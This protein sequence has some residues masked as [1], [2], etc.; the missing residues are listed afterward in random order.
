MI[1]DVFVNKGLQ[2]MELGALYY[3]FSDGYNVAFHSSFI[4]DDFNTIKLDSHY[5]K[6]IDKLQ[7]TSTMTKLLLKKSYGWIDILGIMEHSPVNLDLQIANYG[8]NFIVS[9]NDIKSVLYTSI[10]GMVH[11]IISRDGYR[12]NCK[13]REDIDLTNSDLFTIEQGSIDHPGY[14]F[15]KRSYFDDIKITAV[16]PLFRWDNCLCWVGGVFADYQID[17]I[18]PNRLWIPKGKDLLTTKPIGYKD[19]SE[20]EN[21]VDDIKITGTQ[22]YGYDFAAIKIFR[23]IGVDISPM[24]VPNRFNMSIVAHRDD[25]TGTTYGV[26]YPKSIIFANEVKES[27]IIMYNGIILDP[28]QYTINPKNRCEV[29]LTFLEEHI[30]SL[31]RRYLVVDSNPYERIERYISSCRFVVI[32]FTNHGDDIPLYMRDDQ[33]CHVN[34]PYPGQIT[35]FDLSLSD[36]IL[37]DGM[38]MPYLWIHDRSIEYPKTVGFTDYN[39]LNKMTV[40]KISFFN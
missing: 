4:Y 33:S 40:R 3:E 38:Y 31:I 27:H 15:S 25:I 37:L 11:K 10:D 22:L 30:A 19:V 9:P 5:K 8:E 18:V 16:D 21:L 36:L 17:P 14:A 34:Y 29:F 26:K 12:T 39:L 20:I 7:Q 24:A 35:F 23:W 1:V 6:M 32:N 2:S 28:S 13:V